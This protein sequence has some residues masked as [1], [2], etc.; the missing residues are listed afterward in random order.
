MAA[1]AGHV[2]RPIRFANLWNLFRRIA[3]M[4]TKAAEYK[5][6]RG[7]FDLTPPIP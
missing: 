3:E 7:S 6:R 4:A 1:I 5:A 2:T